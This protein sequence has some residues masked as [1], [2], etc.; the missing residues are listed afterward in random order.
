MP[1]KPRHRDEPA[2][3]H[4]LRDALNHGLTNTNFFVWIDVEPSGTARRFENLRAMVAA[5]EV[6]LANLDPDAIDP[7]ALPEQLF[8]DPAGEV[9][10]TAI[11]K[12]PSARGRQPREIVGN[13]EPV[14]V[15]WD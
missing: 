10:I 11:L 13:P 2:L 8:R 5:T 1:M 15:G 3:H 12:K 14:V 9:R 7:A 4:E 6:W